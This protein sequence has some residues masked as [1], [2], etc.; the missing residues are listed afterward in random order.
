MVNT[1]T[2][3]V[4]GSNARAVMVKMARG[5]EACVVWARQ[6]VVEVIVLGEMV[7]AIA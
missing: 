4:T 7:R 2:A 5:S 6:G 1:R 3:G